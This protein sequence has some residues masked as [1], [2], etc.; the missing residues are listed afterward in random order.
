MTPNS[1]DAGSHEIIKLHGIVASGIYQSR[2]FTE[3]PWVRKQFAEKLGITPYPGT[4][5]ITVVAEDREKLNTIRESKGIEIVPEDTNFC[6]ANSFPVLISDKIKG[7]A[8]IPLVPDYPQAQLEI[9]SAENIRRS[10]SL[11]DGDLVE[12]EVYL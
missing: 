3:I 2:F 10:L 5:N 9:I 12:V 8:I 7:A 11:K 4:F 6:A 1:S